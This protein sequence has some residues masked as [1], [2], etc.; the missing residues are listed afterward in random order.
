MEPGIRQE[1]EQVFESICIVGAGRVGRALA[2][3][4]SE[5]A[6]Q[7]RT[8]G[9]DL[10][11]DGADLVVICVPDRAI[12]AVARAVATGPWIAHTSGAAR[13]EVL[14]P[15]RRRFSLHPLQT[16]QAGLGPGQLDG[17][18]AAVSGESPE[19]IGTGL[20][21]A[22][23]LGVRAFELADA[24]RP[25]YHAAATMAASFLVTL[26][27]AAAELMESAGAPVEGLAPLMRRTVDNGF[28]PT[29]P[30]VRGDQVTIEAHLEAIRERRPRLEPLYRVLAE[31]TTAAA[32]R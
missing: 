19:A 8:T 9:R 17:T 2:D 4:L 26:H 22:D 15:H 23:T 29:G 25:A 7:V 30:F 24:D 32:G 16:F 28:A 21:L 27:G 1:L 6:L 18:F 14:A 11:V 5:R 3:R 31:A 13:L 20:W 12:G 10:R